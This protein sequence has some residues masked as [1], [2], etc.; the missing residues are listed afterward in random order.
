MGHSWCNGDAESLSQH[1]EG[2]GLGE[3]PTHGRSVPRGTPARSGPILLDSSPARK[4][5]SCMDPALLPHA[6]YPLAPGSQTACYLPWLKVS[7]AL[8]SVLSFPWTPDAWREVRQHIPWL[9]A[10]QDR[11]RTAGWFN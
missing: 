5:G 4:E 1:V 8:R 3:A 11:F 2:G 6:P 9:L 10:E 7:V